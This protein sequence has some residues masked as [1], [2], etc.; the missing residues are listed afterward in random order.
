M[1]GQPIRVLVVDD[2]LTV[3]RFLVDLIARAP[4]FE[5]VGEAGDGRSAIELT[6]RLKPDVITMDMMLPVMTGVAATEYIMAFCPT[7][8]LI[9]SAST[10]R[11][12]LFRT[13]D[14]LAA[15]AVDVL[16]KP[17]GD[18]PDEAWAMSILGALRV[19]SRVRVITHLRGRLGAVGRPALPPS[20]T[21][22]RP[23]GDGRRRLVGVGASTGGPGA[24]LSILRALPRDFRLPILMVMHMAEPFGLAMTDW[25]DAQTSVRVRLAEDGE[26]L[27]EPG[28]ALVLMAPPG[29]HLLV[30]GPRLRLTGDP[31]RWSCRPSVDVL[32]ESLALHAPRDTVACLL[33]GMGKDGAAGLLALRERGGLTVAQDQATSIVFGM[34]GEAVRLGAAAPVLARDAIAPVLAAGPGATAQG[35]VDG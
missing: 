20:T 21:A 34:P 7:P 16:D 2:S 26:R 35:G 32:F 33:T 19:A 15:G 13:Y 31:E 27:P 17:S 18:E 10:N 22:P 3:R 24:V 23:D 8:I 29:R 30:D 5:V 4:G 28:R 11:G 14:A 9:V 25:L 12:E 1:T 6:Q